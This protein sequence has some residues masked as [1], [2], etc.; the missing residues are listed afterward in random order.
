MKIK[1]EKQKGK[2][3]KKCHFINITTDANLWFSNLDNELKTQSECKKD[4]KGYS[5]SLHGIKSVKSFKRFV[6]KNKNLLK[7]GNRLILVNRYIGYNIS[8]KK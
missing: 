3:I 7:D 5:S 8:F 6:L 4:N 2:R 1:Y